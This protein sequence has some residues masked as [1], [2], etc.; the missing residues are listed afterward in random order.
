MARKFLQALQRVNRPKSLPR[1][2]TPPHPMGFFHQ[3]FEGLLPWVLMIYGDAIALGA[4]LMIFRKH[5]ITGCWVNILKAPEVWRG[6]IRASFNHSFHKN[7]ALPWQ[8]QT[9]VPEKIFSQVKSKQNGKR[10]TVCLRGSFIKEKWSNGDG[11]TKASQCEG[12]PVL[13][14]ASAHAAVGAPC[15]SDRLFPNYCRWRTPPLPAL[16]F[17]FFSRLLSSSVRSEGYLKH[18]VSEIRHR[19]QM[20]ISRQHR[21]STGLPCKLA[22]VS[23][24]WLLAT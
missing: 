8:V 22:T 11:R 1:C 12:I 20:P 17:V 16:L 10:R 5:G 9:A 6:E 18:N 21:K 4:D 7:S 3:S 23:S 15:W 2:Q 14:F 13:S 19:R 24:M